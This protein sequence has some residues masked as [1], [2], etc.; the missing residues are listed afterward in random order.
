MAGMGIWFVI[1]TLTLNS[2]KHLIPDPDARARPSIDQRT[3]FGHC[4]L[5]QFAANAGLRMHVLPVA[6]KPN[7]GVS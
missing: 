4:H 6:R 1:L 5:H 7:I 3:G 2:N